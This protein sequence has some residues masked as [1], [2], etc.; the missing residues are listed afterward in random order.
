MGKETDYK[1][2]KWFD[3]RSLDANISFNGEVESPK[4]IEEFA[5]FSAER[6]R[7]LKHDIEQDQKSAIIVRAGWAWKHANGKL[8]RIWSKTG[9]NGKV[10][11][12]STHPAEYW[13]GKTIKGKR[14]ANKFRKRW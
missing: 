9:A 8:T 13:I 11:R 6:A 4:R 10:Y 5:V 14:I 7:Q 2:L 1:D 12:Q 3:R